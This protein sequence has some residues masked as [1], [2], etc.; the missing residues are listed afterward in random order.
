MAK[1][2]IDIRDDISP[3]IALLC[4]S[5]VVAEG[6]ISEGER[7][8]KYYCWA[9]GFKTL[10]GDIVVYTRQYRKNDCFMVYKKKE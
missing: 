2:E 1:I 10:D 4:V 7:G 5:E 8:K 9:S 6:K 3:S